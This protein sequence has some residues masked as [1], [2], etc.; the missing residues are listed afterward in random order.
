MQTVVNVAKIFM[1]ILC[2]SLSLQDLSNIFILFMYVIVC[3]YSYLYVHC[4]IV[5]GTV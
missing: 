2:K 5:V 3:R 1:V 4:R